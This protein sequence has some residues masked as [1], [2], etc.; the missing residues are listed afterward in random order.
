MI[1]EDKVPMAYFS[2][3]TLNLQYRHGASHIP[4]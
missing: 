3:F 1:K 2:A 4:H